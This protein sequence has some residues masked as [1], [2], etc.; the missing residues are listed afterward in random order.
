M[1]DKEQEKS[2]HKMLDNSIKIIDGVK[3][4]PEDF[5]VKHAKTG[6]RAG[7]KKSWE[8]LTEEQKSERNK[9]GWA[10]RRKLSTD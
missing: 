10:T 7:G 5:F 9:K 3:Y 2:V 1:T 6:G 8:G 4:Y